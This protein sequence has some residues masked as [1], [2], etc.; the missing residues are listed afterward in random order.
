MIYQDSLGN[1]VNFVPEG[2]KINEYFQQNPV[3]TS[4][5]QAIQ[6]NPYQA[7]YPLNQQTSQ[8]VQPEFDYNEEFQH[9][10]KEE[11]RLPTPIEEFNK[12]NN[13]VTPQS[14]I[15]EIK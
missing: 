12:Q 15:E 14:K 2:L 3:I 5:F 8:Y 7:Q 10:A 4:S 6:R 11:S 1:F 13:V 9:L